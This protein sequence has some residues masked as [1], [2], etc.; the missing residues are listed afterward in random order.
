MMKGL[1]LTGKIGEDTVAAVLPGTE[2]KIEKENFSGS[3][4]ACGGHR[5]ND[6]QSW[7]LCILSKIPVMELK[8]KQG[9]Q[10]SHFGGTKTGKHSHLIS[11]PEG[12]SCCSRMK[13]TSSVLSKAGGGLKG[14]RDG[15][16]YN[17]HFW[18]THSRSTN[19]VISAAWADDN[20][21]EESTAHENQCRGEEC[22]KNKTKHPKGKRDGL[23]KLLNTFQSSDLNDEEIQKDDSKNH[24]KV[25][26]KK[27][28]EDCDFLELTTVKD[29]AQLSHQ[30]H[31]GC[32]DSPM[33]KPSGN[34]DVGPF[35][36]LPAT[37]KG[38]ER[39]E[40][41]G[42][43]SSSHKSG[44]TEPSTSSAHLEDDAPRPL[45]TA[46]QLMQRAFRWLHQSPFHGTQEMGP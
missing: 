39:A 45:S 22:P 31:E 29:P 35:P 46:S 18:T 14:K 37:P 6:A 38:Q 34:T 27:K 32:L 19:E 23:V 11:L 8:G 21:F 9:L 33:C 30:E 17:S 7:H 28:D 10:H 15:P 24:Q 36:E 2:D 40:R 42:E 26:R 25:Q 43:V 44:T 3:V 20:G 1:C 13:A 5:S 12:S 4:V 41:A 16:A